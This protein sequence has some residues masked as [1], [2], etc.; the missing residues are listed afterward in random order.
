VSTILDTIENPAVINAMATMAAFIP[1]PEGPIMAAALR[2]AAMWISTG[3]SI[4]DVNA[5]VTRYSQEAQG[6]A[7]GWGKP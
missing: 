7:D 2:L 4:D 5:I 6:I 1:P 3:K